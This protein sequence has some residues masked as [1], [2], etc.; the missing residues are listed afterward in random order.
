[1]VGGLQRAVPTD[2]RKSFPQIPA[3]VQFYLH[4][5]KCI[6]SKTCR[7]NGNIEFIPYSVLKYL[8]DL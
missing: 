4:R 5:G 8:T 2:N 1:M 7:S 6:D 3:A